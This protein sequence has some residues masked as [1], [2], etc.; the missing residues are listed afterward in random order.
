MNRDLLYGMVKA[1]R[2]YAETLAN[3]DESN[4]DSSDWKDCISDISVML[5][6]V[7]KYIMYGKDE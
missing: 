4:L 5:I 6:A 1:I 7:E 2:K 3:W